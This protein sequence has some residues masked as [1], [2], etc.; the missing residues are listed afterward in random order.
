MSKGMRNRLAD[1]MRAEA[2][3]QD[4]N[5][6]EDSPE[7]VIQ[8]RAMDSSGKLYEIGTVSCSI[9]RSHIRHIIRNIKHAHAVGLLEGDQPQSPIKS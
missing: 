7:K 8:L 1:Q 4:M 9:P 2:A 5:V 6:L 3:G